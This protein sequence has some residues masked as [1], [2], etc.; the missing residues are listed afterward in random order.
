MERP[1]LAQATA[2]RVCSS[3]TGPESGVHGHLDA[4]GEAHDVR[5]ADACSGWFDRVADRVAMP[6]TQ[7]ASQGRQDAFTGA[8]PGLASGL[9]LWVDGART[10]V[11]EINESRLQPV[12]AVVGGLVDS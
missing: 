6:G 12:E 4:W 9:L 5:R 8:E 11:A 2:A 3:A 10:A 1:G 7:A